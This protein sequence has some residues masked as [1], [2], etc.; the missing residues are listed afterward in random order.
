MIE[1]QNLWPG[2]GIDREET[3]PKI[4][5]HAPWNT[6]SEDVNLFWFNNK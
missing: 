1:I 6:V 4:G 5:A 2:L 3:S